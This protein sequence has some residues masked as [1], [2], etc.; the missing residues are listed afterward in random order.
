MRKLINCLITT[1]VLAGCLSNIQNAEARPC[2]SGWLDKLGCTIDPTNPRENGTLKVVGYYHVTVKNVS[3]QKI[4]VAAHYL[5]EPEDPRSGYA[6][7]WRSNGYWA[8]EPGESALILNDADRVKNRIIYFHAH[9]AKGSTWG[10]SDLR[11]EIRG[12][13]K[14]FF[15]ADMGSGISSFTQRFD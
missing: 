1:A 6:A 14:P 9:D 5:Q 13:I 3:N 7:G 15:K 12:T 11:E 4:W 10:N 2:G 8:L